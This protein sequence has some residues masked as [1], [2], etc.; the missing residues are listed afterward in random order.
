MKYLKL[1]L[2]IVFHLII[3]TS[4]S[5]AQFFAKC[6]DGFRYELEGNIR[7]HEEHIYR[8]NEKFLDGFYEQK[9]LPSDFE[10]ASLEDIQNYLGKM[11]FRRAAVLYHA[12]KY[13][14]LCTW[15]ITKDKIYSERDW[16]NESDVKA[17]QPRI[18]DALDVTREA[19]QRAPRRNSSTV[20]SSSN[21]TSDFFQSQVLHHASQVLFPDKIASA[22]LE[23][24]FDTLI[25]VPIAS[26]GT[27]P[28]AALPLGDRMLVD[29]MSVVIAPGFG[30][31]KEER[32][33]AQYD[34]TH[35]I[36]IGDSK[37][38][39][40]EWIL[41]P[42][43]GAR[44]EA[45]EVA[46]LVSV[47]PLIGSEATKNNIMNQLRSDTGLIYLATHG[48]ADSENP[49][50]AS[51]L[52]L[53]DGRW[54]AREIQ[55]MPLRKSRPLVVMS[56]CQTGLGKDFDVGT[57]GMARAW[58]RAGASN[59]VM[60]LWNVNDKATLKLMTRFMHLASGIPPD[61]ALRKAMQETRAAYPNPKYW[62]S[63]SV[64]GAPQLDGDMPPVS[65]VPSMP[66]IELKP[67]LPPPPPPAGER[68]GVQKT[69]KPEILWNTWA[70]ESHAPTDEPS[71]KPVRYLE[72]GGKDYLVALDLSAI[73][74]GKN[75]EGVYTQPG[76]AG[77]KKL[78]DNWLDNDIKKVTLTAVLI[79]DPAH[80][81]Q[82]K[83]FDKP[84]EVDLEKI[85]KLREAGKIEIDRDPYDIM[86]EQEGNPDFVYG[87]VTFRI[88][89][90]SVPFEG[91][92]P[93]SIS[94]W[95]DHRP[96][97]EI[98]FKLCISSESTSSST[99]SGIKSSQFGL[100]G[101]D[102]LRV[103]T[104]K[105]P[106]PD[107][108]LH[109]IE[110]ESQNVYG[111]FRQNDTSSTDY[112]T[113][114]LGTTP[115]EL[116]KTLDDWVDAFAKT[117]DNKDE[118]LKRGTALYN[119]L[120]PPEQSAALS[121][122]E[123]F[124]K[125]YLSLEKT[126]ADNTAPSIFIRL[127]QQSPDPPLL[128]PLGLM[129]VQPD[130][131]DAKFIGF[132]F[133]IETPLQI[134]TYQPTEECVS[135]WVMLFPSEQNTNDELKKAAMQFKNWIPVWRENALK[136]FENMISFGDWIR[137]KQ[138]DE[139]SVALVV[140]SHHTRNRISFEPFQLVTS[141]EV[142]RK[143]SKPSMAIL[144]GCGTGSPGAVD[145]VKQFNKNG[146]NTIIATSTEVNA[147]M[148]GDFLDSLS[149]V[150]E[151][152]KQNTKFNISV[153]YFE[154]L[155]HL[156]ERTPPDGDSKYGARVLEYILVGNGNI[157]LCAPEK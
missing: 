46:R 124:L 75:E 63:F 94:L 146:I 34:F 141:H 59:V 85:K 128:I 136:S 87:R 44:K 11:I 92:A 7:A 1:L 48:M 143:F 10:G 5:Q 38:T 77:F 105:S 135:R 64:Y 42:L 140:L 79:A 62:A 12:Y 93:I 102:S 81:E 40:R 37:A 122:F 130:N 138:T 100:K 15:L 24:Q 157:R 134:Q 14:H 76:L 29:V 2:F 20:G 90:T 137:E 110:L 21:P 78:I 91:Y 108:S 61:K 117:R 66:D 41:P 107:A 111:I 36:V 98:S 84:I 104:E 125:P 88:K 71:F 45:E 142:V 39:D 54:T 51:V 26:I 67:V 121:A 73:S 50:D 57:I 80:F 150:L 4:L 8:L 43:P 151:K 6:N 17:L 99:C 16:V 70:E 47:S 28:F 123:A 156:R 89:T 103:A 72:K 129:A 58:H 52:W 30:I 153:A 127:I 35:S 55:N 147:T 27:I 126:T 18:L 113:W 145:F 152:N 139:D 144:N 56:A 74:Y 155:K 69:L 149:T 60:S 96:V 116:R 3:M 33:R 120:F 13:D 119:I 86:S 65:A 114:R 49:L 23:E 131:S 95:V 154:A 68:T 82:P 115:V 132:Y 32:R 97:D 101:V 112:I 9:K 31:F 106:F 22:L 109:F 53:S 25:V 19:R 133:R 118:L 148:A 83:K